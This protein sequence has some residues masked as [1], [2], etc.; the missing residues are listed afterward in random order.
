MLSYCGSLG[1][2]REVFRHLLEFGSVSR[3]LCAVE[4]DGVAWLEAYYTLVFLCG[5]GCYG[6]GW[7]VGATHHVLVSNEREISE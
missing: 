2:V 7:A 3:E 6:V 4:F 1:E 5:S